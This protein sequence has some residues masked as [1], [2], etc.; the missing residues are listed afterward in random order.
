MLKAYR[1]VPEE[2][3]SQQSERSLISLKALKSESAVAFA[4]P[5]C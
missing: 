1:A 4:Q 5:L 2:E 3:S